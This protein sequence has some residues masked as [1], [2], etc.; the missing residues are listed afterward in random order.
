MTDLTNI[1]DDFIVI[2]PDAK[3]M[4]A[5]ETWKAGLKTEE[6]ANFTVDS[7][8]YIVS[9][10]DPT[11]VLDATRK[12]LI[13]LVDANAE[14]PTSVVRLRFTGTTFSSIIMLVAKP[15]EDEK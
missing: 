5:F 8:K 15:P 11:G 10:P 6:K 2:C 4:A 3:T 13:A 7:G 1:K 9:S 12:E 14:T